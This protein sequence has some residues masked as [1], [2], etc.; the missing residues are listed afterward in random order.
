MLIHFRLLRYAEK[1]QPAYD[2]Y[3]RMVF[4]EMESVTWADWTFRRNGIGSM[5]RLRQAPTRENM[6]SD[7]TYTVRCKR[8]TMV[9]LRTTQ[10]ALR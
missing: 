4:A 8:C 3:V 5:T 9:T 7:S 1:V 6:S 2:F 10:T